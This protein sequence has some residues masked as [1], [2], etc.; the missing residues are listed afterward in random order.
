MFCISWRSIS[1]VVCQW[2]ATGLWFSPGTPIYSTNKTDTQDITEIL[3]KVALSTMNLSKESLVVKTKTL[4]SFVRRLCLLTCRTHFDV[5]ISWLS[6]EDREH[7]LTPSP[8]IVSGQSQ[9]ISRSYILCVLWGI[10][11]V[12]VST[13]LWLFR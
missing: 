3:L 8:I 5:R 10:Y 6:K 4:N 2:L 12:F 9:E 13:I 7:N 11:F 1:L